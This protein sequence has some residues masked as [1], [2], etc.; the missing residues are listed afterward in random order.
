MKNVFCFGLLSL[1]LL[2]GHSQCYAKPTESG[3][4]G[5]YYYVDLGLSV[6]WAT[7]NIGASSCYDSGD[8]FAW[9][10]TSTKSSF[11]WSNYKWND[12]GKLTKYSKTD[13][14]MTLDS[15]DDVAAVKWGNFWRIPTAQEVNELIGGC[16]W[17]WIKIP[18]IYNYFHYFTYFILR[19]YRF[20][21]L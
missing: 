13:G 20:C 11:S 16:D 5:D 1:G 21:T 18:E 9:G 6:K 19:H 15:K 3:K 17:E 2:L 4:L 14:I 8:L 7:Y 12:G 10:E